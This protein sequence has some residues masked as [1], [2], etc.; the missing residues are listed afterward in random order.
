MK[1]IETVSCSPF[2]PLGLSEKCIYALIT[3]QRSL[4]QVL[5]RRASLEMDTEDY[6][7]EVKEDRLG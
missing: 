1:G 2:L 7:F 4:R 5:P 3:I 6:S